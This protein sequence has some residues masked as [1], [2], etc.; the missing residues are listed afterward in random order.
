MRPAAATGAR[1]S[2]T[3][4]VLPACLTVTQRTT[5]RRAPFGMRAVDSHSWANA[6][7]FR[8]GIPHAHGMGFA[9][10]QRI[11]EQDT[12]S[13]EARL[14]ET[15]QQIVELPGVELH[16]SLTSVSTRVAE[17]LNCEKVDTFLLDEA[18]QT[19]FAMGTSETPMG[20]RQRALGLHSLALANGGRIVQVFESGTSY[21]EHH[22][23]Q[24]P[25]ELAGIVENL[26]VR[27]TVSVPLEVNGVRRGVLTAASALPEFFQARD[28]NFLTI[29]S[30]WIGML[31]HRAE[32]AE[33]SRKIETEQAR[34]KGADE[35][36]T[37]LAHDLR[38]HLQPLIGRLQ[39]MR[40]NIENGMPVA[41]SNV[42]SALASAQRLA[43]LTE[44]LLDMK[45]LD[46]GLFSLRLAPVDLAVLCRETAESLGTGTVPVQASGEQSLVA[47]VDEE[48]I[49]QTVENLVSNAIKYSPP[50]K[51]VQ[52][53]VSADIGQH[54]SSA[55]VEVLDS[56]PGISREVAATLFDRFSFSS[57]SKGLGLGLYLAHE[58]ARV[59]SGELGVYTR[60][61]G[62]TRFKLTLPLD[63]PDNGDS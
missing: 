16:E 61:A 12:E 2:V 10:P 35:V 51:A 50:G 30:R 33:H 4:A 24:D 62:G 6:H 37:V 7:E 5:S 28:L 17:V 19:L 34:R 41:L 15:L 56:G 21:L 59:H 23:D 49:R 32:L 42:G 14:L 25:E 38:N 40:L 26:A 36:I 1:R 20:D 29:T 46:E 53:R 54:T 22:A 45:R 18:H 8:G 60:P 3:L 48:R 31:C 43:R 55:V 58:I 13:Q 44:D 39:M 9:M 27:S 57:D 63:P 11:T 47:V 52:L